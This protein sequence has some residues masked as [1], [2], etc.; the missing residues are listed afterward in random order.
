MV[1]AFL[2]LASGLCFACGAGVIYFMH[3]HEVAAFLLVLTSA[4]LLVGACVVHALDV[5]TVQL[6]RTLN[7]D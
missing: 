1:R 2:F 5:L 7:A 3:G 6:S 4:V